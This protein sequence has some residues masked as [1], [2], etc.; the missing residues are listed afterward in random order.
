MSEKSISDT[1]E[2]TP[3][4]PPFT[5]SSVVNVGTGERILSIAGAVALAIL[6]LR[7]R[8]PLNLISM[9]LGSG[10]LLS[11]GITGYCPINQAIGRN[12]AKTPASSLEVFTSVTVR[13]PREEVYAF[14]RNLRNLP[15]F[16][17]HLQKVEQKD[18]VR[19]HWEARFPGSGVISWD[20][21]ILFEE[22]G[23]R[24]AW[25]SVEGSMIDTVGE[26]KFTDA[27][28]WGTEVQVDIKYRVPA[29]DAGKLIGKI[30]N[31]AIERM[32]KEDIRRFKQLMETG[33][34]ATVEGQATA[35]ESK[36]ELPQTIF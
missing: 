16:M 36:K 14:W 1:P 21:E 11:R 15:S 8:T 4:E 27:G 30:F 28:K 7:R 20:A 17:R 10:A 26:V 24:I 33:E 18:Q 19:S 29:G 32:V 12:T 23:N 22:R 13:K 25:E 2:H 5:G 34:I 9:A 35:R 31:P 6:G 3:M